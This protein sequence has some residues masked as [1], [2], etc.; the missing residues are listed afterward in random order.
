MSVIDVENI[1]YNIG[2]NRLIHSVSF[3]VQ[4]GTF[5]GLLGPNG[6][7]KTTLLR[8]ISSQLK[9]AQGKISLCGKDMA[10]YSSDELARQRSMLSQTSSISFPFTVYEVVC[11]GRT[12]HLKGVFESSHDRQI[13]DEAMKRAD[14]LHL[15]DRIY[16]TLSGGEAHRVDVARILAQET[17]LI[18]LDEPTNHLDPHHQVAVLS[19]FRKL[20]DQGKTVIAAL[21]DLNLASLFCDRVIL[22]QQ[23]EIKADGTPQDVMSRQQIKKVYDIECA[24]L[25]HP[26]GIPWIAPVLNTEPDSVEPE[27]CA[28]R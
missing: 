18:L 27:P 7:G 2:N 8:L 11:M 3:S 25:D 16:P 9:P 26:S 23:G 10:S 15:K 5:V 24:V 20:V 4:A 21:H 1:H 13:C 22:M 6:A 12:P 19:I 17:N 28:A 14:V